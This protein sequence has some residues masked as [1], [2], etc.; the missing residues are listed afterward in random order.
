M[1]ST[2]QMRLLYLSLDNASQRTV[3]VVFA[4]EDLLGFVALGNSTSNRE[5]LVSKAGIFDIAYNVNL[6]SVFN[7]PTGERFEKYLRQQL[8]NVIKKANE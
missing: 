2:S 8:S 1:A 7:D 5:Y 6:Y 3:E 4:L